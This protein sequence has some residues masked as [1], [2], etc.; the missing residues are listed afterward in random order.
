MRVALTLLIAVLHRLQLLA[1]PSTVCRS[2]SAPPFH[3]A[4]GRDGDL[5]VPRPHLI[6]RGGLAGTLRTCL[7][8]A[9][10][11]CLAACTRFAHDV[12]REMTVGA[13]PCRSCARREVPCGWY[14]V[15]S[16]TVRLFHLGDEGGGLHH[17]GFTAVRLLDEASSSRLS[18]PG[19]DCGS[20]GF[21]AFSRIPLHDGDWTVSH[22][23]H[24]RRG[25]A[26]RE[27]W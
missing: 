26:S 22:S 11:T 15:E 13:P 9:S 10:S 18:A 24:A 17:L 5:T 21:P 7:M 3:P 4:P 12:P 27:V 14:C 23:T 16:R 19:H 2:V 25:V 20:G 8:M 6:M 1:S